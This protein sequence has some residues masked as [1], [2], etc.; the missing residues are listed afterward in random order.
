MESIIM[1]VTRYTCL[2]EIFIY[3]YKKVWMHVYITREQITIDISHVLVVM[4][5]ERNC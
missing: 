1:A 3:A 2:I 5:G 4:Y